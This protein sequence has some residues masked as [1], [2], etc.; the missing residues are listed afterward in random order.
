MTLYVQ[1]CDLADA[2]AKAADLGATVTAEPFDVPGGPTLAAITDPEA[3]PVVLV[4]Q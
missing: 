2:L 1:V 3:N 4:Q